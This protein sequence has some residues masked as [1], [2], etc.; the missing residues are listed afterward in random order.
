[1][2][3]C[4]FLSK[5]SAYYYDHDAMKEPAVQAGRVRRDRMGGNKYGEG[6]KHSDGAIF[7][8]SDTRNRRSVWSVN[9]QPFKGAHFATFPPELIRP[10]I[11]AGSRP[12]DLVLDP[13]GGAGTTGLVARQEGRNFVLC[14]LNAE[15]VGM[16]YERIY[17][18]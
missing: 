10:C 8:G 12:G 14:E 1:M 9:T 15:Y 5:S 3:T 16:A 6:V 4:F 18:T 11:L 7:T 17:G 13:F 2:N